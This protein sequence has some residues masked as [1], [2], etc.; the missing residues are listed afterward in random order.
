MGVGGEAAAIR[1]E[2]PDDAPAIRRVHEQAFE[3]AGEAE[4]V[5]ALRVAGA[6]VVSLVAEDRG[7]I[8]GHVLF[9]PV[10]IGDDGATGLGLGPVA[11]LPERQRRGIGA[12]LIRHGLAECGRL[13]HGVVVVLGHPGYY[14]RFGFVRASARGLRCEY[15]APDDAFMVVELTPGA[16]RGGG[17]LVRYHPEFGRV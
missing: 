16:L 3:R 5:A 6:A 1:P 7:V 14:P 4:L 12:A 10:A 15:D 8:V 9:S 17:G 11:V 13:G 2:R